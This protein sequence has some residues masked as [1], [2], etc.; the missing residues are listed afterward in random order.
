MEFFQKLE[1]TLTGSREAASSNAAAPPPPV[2]TPTSSTSPWYPPLHDHPAAPFRHGPTS[3]FES[4][5][6]LSPVFP[7]SEPRSLLQQLEASLMQRPG[8]SLTRTALEHMRGDSQS[9][10]VLTRVLKKLTR[11]SPTPRFERR[12]RPR[13]SD[14]RD[15]RDWEKSRSRETS[16]GRRTPE[17]SQPRAREDEKWSPGQRPLPTR[18][19]PPFTPEPRHLA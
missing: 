2:P 13:R 3:G 1:K 19:P 9:E 6:V 18:S 15:S 11:R 17:S 4:P 10:G 14:S 16:R 7:L 12:G 8:A 5:P